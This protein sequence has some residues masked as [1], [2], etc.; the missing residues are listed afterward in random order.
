[1]YK[2]ILFMMLTLSVLVTGCAKENLAEKVYHHLEAAVNIEKPFTE[3]QKPLAEA[4]TKEYE[5]YE[6]ILRLSNMEEIAQQIAIVKGLANSRLE[7]LE[8]EKEGIEAAYAEFLSVIPIVEEIED[9]ELKIAGENLIDAMEQRHD[10][11]QLLYDNYLIAIGLDLE[12]YELILEEDLTIEQLQQQHE[13]VNT[14]YE[15]VNQYKD[16]FNNYTNIYNER[17]KDF[18]LL[19]DLNVIFE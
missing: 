16:D 11:Y 8:I 13:L 6:E 1:M 14:T 17:K 10:T 12:L 5:I 2:M 4:E 7:M 18:Y 15:I 3:Q 19:A 9:G